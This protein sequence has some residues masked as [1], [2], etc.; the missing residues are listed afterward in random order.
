MAVAP[1][2]RETAPPTARAAN[3]SGRRGSPITV[4]IP[5]LRYFQNQLAALDPELIEE[6]KRLN[7]RIGDLVAQAAA[8]RA[9]AVGGVAAKVAPFLKSARAK[10]TA[11]VT[12]NSKR[13][14][15]GAGA[16]FG[17]IRHPQFK[18]WR[19]N[20]EEGGYFL[21]P[22]IRELSPRILREYAE[23]F[24]AIAKRAFPE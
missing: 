11:S 1:P 22:S 21:Y 9:R 23:G 24:D 15:F 3:G 7:F 16:E 17:S 2:V 4:D 6:F 12:Y 10:E 19:G 13:L 14:P 18:P 5:G 8:S 20:G